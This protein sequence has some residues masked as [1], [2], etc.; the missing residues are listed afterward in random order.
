MRSNQ[1]LPICPKNG[2]LRGTRCAGH[3]GITASEK[4]F[5]AFQGFRIPI[6]FLFFHC[7]HPGSLTKH[8]NYETCLKNVPRRNLSRGQSGSRWQVCWALFL[9]FIHSELQVT[10]LRASLGSRGKVV[11]TVQKAHGVGM[12]GLR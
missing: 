3:E 8:R 9:H 1:N 10:E 11:I 7:W 2:S 5:I 4:S 12:M 6:F